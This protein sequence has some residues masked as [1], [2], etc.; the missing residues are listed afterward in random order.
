MENISHPDST[1]SHNEDFTLGLKCPYRIKN[2]KT[3]GE[4]NINV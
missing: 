2:N 4:D 3:S 1:N